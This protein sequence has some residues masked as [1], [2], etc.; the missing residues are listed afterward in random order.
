MLDNFIDPFIHGLNLLG[1]AVFAIS[2]AL[3]A[4]RKRLDIISF[5]LIATVTAVGGGTLRDLLLGISPIGWVGA[6]HILWLCI[7]SA[8]TTYFAAH[9]IEPRYKLLLWADAAG[10]A[11]FAVVGAEI[12]LANGTSGIVAVGMGVMTAT[13]GGIIRDVLC[14]ETSLVL[15][16]E[17]YATAALIGALSYVLM[18]MVLHIDRP[19]AVL[20]A[21]AAGFIIRGLAIV[22]RLSLPIYGR[23]DTA[24][25]A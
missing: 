17:I 25:G 1:T 11:L 22:Y 15:Q 18:T 7:G 5:I 12:A 3:V 8:V 13:F 19:F 14:Q 20:I 9:L 2:G 10:M 16:Q 21:F 6:P 23:N 24:S 4:A